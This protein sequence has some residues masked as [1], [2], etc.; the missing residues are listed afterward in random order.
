MTRLMI[1]ALCLL[2]AGCGKGYDAMPEEHND[3]SSDVHKLLVGQYERS[4]YN[5]AQITDLQPWGER[6]GTRSYRFTFTAPNQYKAAVIATVNRRKEIRS[7]QVESVTG[8][9]PPSTPSTT[10]PTTT[11]QSQQDYYAAVEKNAEENANRRAD[12]RIKQEIET[13]TRDLEAKYAN[14]LWKKT[15]EIRE[16]VEALWR[17]ISFL[18]SAIDMAFQGMHHVDESQL[19][20]YDFAPIHQRAMRH[21][22]LFKELLMYSAHDAPDAIFKRYHL[23]G[24]KIGMPFTRQEAIDYEYPLL[25]EFPERFP[26]P[27]GKQAADSADDVD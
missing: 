20:Q 17:H 3:V 13:A 5:L 18:Q 19:E 16:E 8:L 2:V 6:G 7:I 26:L 11:A 15:Q 4:L 24:R 21:K 12:A 9:E 27:Q 23:M 10:A 25:Q 14:D 1:A 22:V